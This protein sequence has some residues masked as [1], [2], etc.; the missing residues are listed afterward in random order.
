MM[1]GH[2]PPLASNTA[3]KEHVSRLIE[4]AV[5]DTLARVELH[6]E[7]P[8]Q[9]SRLK[10]G[11]FKENPIATAYSA[12]GHDARP[13]GLHHGSIAELLIRTDE[14]YGEGPSVLETDR[15][16]YGIV[17]IGGNVARAGK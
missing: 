12:Y 9:G 13:I 16:I 7:R 2:S 11:R 17:V 3:Y 8:T 15:D 14:A 10:D 6:P 4:V 1:N 5:K